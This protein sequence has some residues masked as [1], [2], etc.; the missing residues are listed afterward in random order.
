M[1]PLIVMDKIDTKQFDWLSKKWFSTADCIGITPSQAKEFFDL[2][3]KQY[4]QKHRAYHNMSH[5][6]SLLHVAEKYN[7]HVEA[8]NLVDLGIWFHDIIYS[9]RRK[10]NEEKSAD[11]AGELLKPYLNTYDLQKIKLMIKATANHQD[12]DD[13][14]DSQYLLDFDLSI[15][16]ANREVYKKYRKA[17]R[18]EFKRYP[19]FLFKMGRRKVLLR[20]LAKD[21]I[22]QTNEFHAAYEAKARENIQWEIEN[23]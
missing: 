12:M 1:L 10:D 2:I 18:K 15:F 4:N 20:F 8:Q 7:D 19:G 23:L 3:C 17:I 6:Y 11:L 22:Y 13:S 21:R 14:I 9:I 5:L 16:A